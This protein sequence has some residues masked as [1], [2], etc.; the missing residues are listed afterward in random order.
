MTAHSAYRT[1]RQPNAEPRN[2]ILPEMRN[3]K[4]I[5]RLTTA[6]MGEVEETLQGS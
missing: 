6:L 5:M 4:V 2:V 3:E 1:T